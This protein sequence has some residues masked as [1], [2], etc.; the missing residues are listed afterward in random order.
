[1]GSLV[2]AVVLLSDIVVIR[3]EC[4]GLTHRTEGVVI[5]ADQQGTLILTCKHGRQKA[6]W[7]ATNNRQQITGCHIA[8]DR[9]ADLALLWSPQRWQGK[10][11]PMAPESSPV[12]LPQKLVDDP[13]LGGIAF[14]W[15]TQRRTEPGE[16]GKPLLYNGAVCGI[17][18]GRLLKRQGTLYIQQSELTR[19]LKAKPVW[20]YHQ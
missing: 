2:V 5:R 1:M 18:W 8:L 7:N 6:S 10:A 17:L 11:T 15:L 9:H 20:S 3:Q 13:T 12:M 14:L 4:N 16:S 19:F